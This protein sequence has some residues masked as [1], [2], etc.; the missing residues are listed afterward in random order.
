MRS[1]SATTRAAVAVCAVAAAALLA[2]GTLRADVAA[3][4]AWTID[5]GVAV[6]V[7]SGNDVYVG[8]AF[9][10]LFTPSTVEDQFY[11][12]VTGQVRT[13]CARSTDPSL[14]LTAYPDNQGG[15]LVPI[16]FNLAFA[17]A[18]GPFLPPQGTTVLRIDTNCTWDRQFA[19]GLIDPNDIFNGAVNQPARAGALIVASNSVF[20]FTTGFLR[21]QTA[22][23]SATSG[24]RVAF[25]DRYQQPGGALVSEL[26]V[27][28]ATAT[29][30]IVRVRT[31]QTG[32]YTLGAIDPATLNLTES[33]S[34]LADESLGVRSW[35]RGNTLY[36]LRP[37]PANTLEAYDLGTL[38]AKSG[39]TPPV[40]PSMADLEVVGG[41]V[42]LAAR[43][44]NGQ[45]LMP[46]AAVLAAS[47][48][49]DTAWSPPA[50]TRRLP[51][52]NGVPYQ[53]VLT[54]LVTDGQR[55]YY[56]GDFERV[57]G[58][59][60]DGVAA[61]TV[62]SAAL[63]AWDTAPW[64]VTPIESTT[65]A[66]LASRPIGANRVTR[67]YLGSI[68]RTT[69]VPTAW[70]PNDPSTALLHTPSPVS[71]LAVDATHVYFA[72]A[73]NGQ[74]LRA[75]RVTAAVDQGWQAVVTRSDGTPGAVTSMAVANGLVYIGG[76]FDAVSGTN[77]S[78]TPRQWLA[79]I[80]LDGRLATWA[81]SLDGN[82]GGTWFR[83]LLAESGTIYLAGDFT[84][85]NGLYLL[86]YAA[87]DGL[88][89]AVTQPLMYV[90]GENS[91]FYGLASDGTQTFVA[92]EAFG[93]PIV[94]AASVPDAVFTPYTPAP[95]QV[96]RS[97]AFVAG[98]LY[99][100]LEYDPDTGAPT[101]RA[102]EWNSV[103]A[104]ALG[105]V[106]VRDDNLL[107]YYPAIPGNP[108]GPPVLT[109]TSSGNTVSVSWTPDAS[110]GTPSSYTLFAGS[111]PGRVDLAAIPI[112]GATSFSA[113]APTGLYYL[114]VVA[115]N[116]YGTSA[117]SNEVAVQAGCVA[118]PPAPGALGYTRF[119]GAVRLAWNAA[120]TASAYHLEAGQSP[121]ATDI[122]TLPL[123]NVTSFA[124]TVP[125]GVYYVRVRA[126]N[127]CG[128]GP[129]SNEVAVN[130]DGATPPPA[131]PTGF[132][133]SVSGR[134]VA[135][136]ITP[137]TTGGMAMGFQVEAGVA[138]GTTIAVLPTAATTLVVPN[139]PPGT[140]YVRVRAVN[141]A[142]ISAPTADVTVVIP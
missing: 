107:E 40:V 81:P 24:V 35:V 105:L 59:D 4:P 56:S 122:G 104:D 29:R 93:A 20:D 63:D 128:V 60:R 61:L 28:G 57:G 39:W 130:L 74:V 12:V 76:T 83:A 11:D 14:P 44:V 94:G 112:R 90:Q 136:Q 126:V 99:A 36:R 18:G 80:G 26:G 38:Q 110:G 58:L 78:A 129:A 2:R 8:G 32:P 97:A 117:P 55:L 132:T 98:K 138:P 131:T 95:A 52:P 101:T 1:R 141:P 69:G 15:L 73:T 13:E 124:A 48:A 30:V 31:G 23:F 133:A 17:D 134:T 65:T 49:I 41:R 47:G 82:P 87:V 62:Q 75:D 89:G 88:S 53:P 19:M 67:R 7:P 119:G 142:G 27:L 70:D 100:G 84:A 9:T 120:A 68:D 118:A 85:V 33:A 66:V 140:F 21:A 125:L 86:G 37:A 10:Q 42:F 6:A 109:A 103:S 22:A 135:F 71:A 121:G 72:S 102:T 116:G 77:F 25:R 51:D 106:H 64:Q 115:R 139:A 91:T 34:V 3:T 46:P 111:A 50:L 5:G 108:P 127:G 54:S 79:A 92:G 43:I 113:V 123:G 16:G 96:P 137:A 45:T 114:T